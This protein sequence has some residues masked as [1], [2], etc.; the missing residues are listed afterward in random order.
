MHIR[1]ILIFLLAF[2]AI[3]AAPPCLA[4]GAA[5][6]VGVLDDEGREVVLTAPAQRVVS[7]APH[8]TENLFAVGAGN[9]IV[10]TTSFSDHPEAATEIPRVGS[11]KRADMERIVAMQP[12]LVVAWASGNDRAQIQRM[13]ELG[14]TVYIS[15]PRNFE[16]IATT[17]ER[18]GRLTGHADTGETTAEALRTGTRALAN[19]YRDATPV[20]VFYQV[21]EQPL[22][23]VNDEHLIDEAITLCGG[24]NVF[25]A[26]E[27]LVPRIDRES[28]LK[29]DPEAIAAGG[30]GEDRQDW[31]E[32]WREWPELQAVREE[33][34]F[35]IPPS[36][37]QR[38]TPRVLQGTRQLCE[39]LDS[40]RRQ[41]RADASR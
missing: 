41:R 33:N 28:V 35:F 24:D 18:L 37:L 16:G 10:G 39:D 22:M 38:H 32:A 19:R 11:Y 13:I 3:F 1:S 5:G 6:S 34:L 14:L 21:W 9:Q 4:E 40:V 36:L 7:L 12:D 15:E 20:T 31:L 27:R 30:M 2:S 26:L 25:G 29:A 23:T 8:L 17:L